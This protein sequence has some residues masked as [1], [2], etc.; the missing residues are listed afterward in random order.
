MG[1]LQAV[2]A[3]LSD[4]RHA[5]GDRRGRSCRA[6]AGRG[7][8]ALLAALLLRAGHVV[9]TEQLVDELY[10]AEPPKTATASLQNSVVALRKALGPD[11]LV[12]RPPGYVLAVSPEQID[13]R[14]F[15]QLLADAR[16]ASA[17]S[18]ARSSSARSTLWRGPPLAEFAFEDWAQAESRRLDELRLVAV[19]ERIART[20]SSAAP[21]DVVPELESLV[22]EHP[23]RERPLRAADARPLSGGPPGGRARARTRTPRCARRARPRAGRQGPAPTGRDPPPRAGLSP[24]RN[25]GRAARRRRGDREGDP[26]GPLV[27]VLGLDGA[28][29]L[30]AEL[31]AV[32]GY[33]SE[34]PLDLARVSQYVATMNGS[35]PLYDELHSRFE[36]AVEPQ[37]VHRFLA[38]LAAAPAGA[39]RAA[40]A[41]RLGPLRPRDRAGVRG[42][43][44][45][46][47]RRH[48]RR[49]RALPREVLAPASERGAA[50]DR[51][52]QHVRHRAVARAPHGAAQA[53]RRG[54][55]VPGARVGELR[56]HG[57]RL[58]RLP[59][60]LR[61][62]GRG[63]GRARRAASAQPFPLPRVRD[64]R[65][66]PEARHA[67]GLGGPAGRLSVVGRRPGADAA[68]AGLLA[69]LRRR[70]ARRR[71][72]R[73]R[74]AAR[75]AA[76]G[77]A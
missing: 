10:G 33:P 32:F 42:G 44:R 52:A 49:R 75:A 70:R 30:A 67:P 40:P 39:R 72:R 7:Q 68:R 59:R 23:L 57:G 46:G 54:R 62:R 4:P 5:R 63:P 21:A 77:L 48:V 71:P 19:E 3:G 69:P 22:G 38:W 51:R 74:R 37:P 73:V 64:G 53:A 27:P 61:R 2:H 15:E 45:G 29:D 26:R 20:S 43:G 65:L 14:R 56:D 24:G 9:P 8:R 35:G 34:P 12:T 11:V 28:A 50:A 18:A 25:G 66:E 13:A 6:R 47:R 1:V 76:R 17:E 16:S 58:H 60:P 36:A 55:P 31:A 41:H